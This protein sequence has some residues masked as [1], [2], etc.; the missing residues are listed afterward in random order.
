MSNSKRKKWS[1]EEKFKMVMGLL[2]EKYSQIEICRNYQV[3]PTQLHRWKEIFLER[4][5]KVFSNPGLNS[6]DNPYKKLEEL[7]KI[8]GQQTIE[9]SVLKKTLNFSI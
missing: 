1:D 3:H 2:S 6:T 5:P 9:N 7:E 8:I 4:A